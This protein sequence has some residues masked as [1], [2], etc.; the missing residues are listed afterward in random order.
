MIQDNEMN[1]LASVINLQIAR[2]YTEDFKVNTMGILALKKEKIY[3]PGQIK[4]VDFYRFEGISDPGDESI[5]YVIETNDGIKGTLVDSFGANSDE[6]TSAFMQ[7]VGEISKV[8]DGENVNRFYDEGKIEE[9]KKP[10]QK[11]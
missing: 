11:E 4:V 5:L 3:Q 6:L 2:G 7:K 1:T 10:E 9:N 8:I